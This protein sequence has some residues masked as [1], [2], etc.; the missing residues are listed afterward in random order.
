MHDQ[1]QLRNPRM[2]SYLLYLT[3]TLVTNRDSRGTVPFALEQNDTNEILIPPI[4][5][6]PS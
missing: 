5:D 4:M 1:G 6:R 3:Q 2:A